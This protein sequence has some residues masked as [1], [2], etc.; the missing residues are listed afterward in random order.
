MPAPIPLVL[1]ELGL[2]VVSPVV[3]DAN[4]QKSMSALELGMIESPTSSV[5]TDSSLQE[6][7]QTPPPTSGGGLFSWV[8]E[9]IPGKQ[10]LAKVAEKAKSSMDY[11][12]TT[13]DPQMK[14]IICKTSSIPFLFQKLIWVPWNRFWRQHRYYS[15]FQQGSQS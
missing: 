1:P 13:L 3:V 2:P 15:D 10:I 8:R 4:F 12:I 9:A 14:E 5:M 7:K 6:E 11:A